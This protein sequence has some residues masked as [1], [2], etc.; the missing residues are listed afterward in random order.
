MMYT[1]DQIVNSESPYELFPNADALLENRD[2]IESLTNEEQNKLVTRLIIG[3]PTKDLKKYAH[4][5]Q[6]LRSL[7]GQNSHFYD[8]LSTCHQIRT[9]FD[10]ILDPR[11]ARPQDLIF[12]NQI[13]EQLVSGYE[14]FVASLIESNEVAIA[15]RFVIAT[16]VDEQTRL[17]DRINKLFNGQIIVKILKNAIE[18]RN[19]IEKELLSEQPQVFFANDDDTLK[20]CATFNI[21]CQH[22]LAD[23]IETLQQKL[24][25]L[26]STEYV[27][28]IASGL[29]TINTACSS[30]VNP[31]K[32]IAEAR[33]NRFAVFSNAKPAVSIEQTSKS[34]YNN[35]NI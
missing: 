19:L 11:L 13:N 32:I 5:I 25:K 28:K 30:P 29:N 9:L 2:V 31:F 27:V 24:V 15:T 1:I 18:I 34:D 12:N 21:L 26:M 20:K 35:S 6:A 33:Y 3:I 23:Q 8:A 16:S 4:A 7:T 10:S 22:L 17:F 14:D